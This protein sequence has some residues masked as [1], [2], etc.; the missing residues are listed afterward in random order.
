MESRPTPWSRDRYPQEGM[1]NVLLLIVLCNGI[2]YLI[3]ISKARKVS[4]P[5]GQKTMRCT[6]V[7]VLR[8]APCV[9][10]DVPHLG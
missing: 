3:K 6:M 1:E 2:P 4:F 5:T 10:A 7:R 9:I 8:L